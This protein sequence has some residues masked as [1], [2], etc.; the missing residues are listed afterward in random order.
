MQSLPIAC[1]QCILCWRTHRLQT[2]A[3]ACMWL[4]LDSCTKAVLLWSAQ[5]N[6]TTLGI[7]PLQPQQ[8]PLR[9]AT[10]HVM[11][12]AYGAAAADEAGTYFM[13]HTFDGRRALLLWRSGV[14]V[15]LACCIGS[16]VQ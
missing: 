4:A 5:A 13:A 8:G 11:L 15:G 6:S 1:K 16:P 12:A 10:A 14:A 9:I 3:A 2:D 7:I